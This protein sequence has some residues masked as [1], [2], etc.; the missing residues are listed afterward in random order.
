MERDKNLKFF[1]DVNF[2]QSQLDIVQFRDPKI[3]N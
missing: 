2:V 1:V 3:E